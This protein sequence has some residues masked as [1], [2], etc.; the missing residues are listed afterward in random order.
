MLRIGGKGGG[1]EEN[2]WGERNRPEWSPEGGMRTMKRG[3]PRR[4]M[5]RDLEKECI[6]YEGMRSPFCG[7]P[8]YGNKGACHPWKFDK[9][10]EIW[11]ADCRE[12]GS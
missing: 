2:K 1:R 5:L 6:R 12:K 9:S 4:K 3:E 10:G 8:H 7:S 11:Y